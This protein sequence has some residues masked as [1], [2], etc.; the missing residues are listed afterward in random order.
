ML[1][2]NVKKIQFLSALKILPII[3]VVFYTFIMTA[4][5]IVINFISEKLNGGV[6][7]SIESKEDKTD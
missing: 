1:A 7:I 4:R 5:L 2:Y 3:F 6:I